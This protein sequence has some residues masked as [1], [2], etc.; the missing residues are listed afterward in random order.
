MLAPFINAQGGLVMDRPD[1]DV[2]LFKQ[3]L[4][5]RLKEFEEDCKRIKRTEEKLQQKIDGATTDYEQVVHGIAM[6]MDS[7]IFR[8]LREQQRL[9]VLQQQEIDQIRYEKELLQEETKKLR[10]MMNPKGSS[11]LHLKRSVERTEPERFGRLHHVYHANSPARP[12]EGMHYP[13]VF[14]TSGQTGW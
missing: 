5:L 9:I 10:E 6:S 1:P 7:R 11:T 12:L 2:L 14:S 4:D 8:R 13:V 3:G